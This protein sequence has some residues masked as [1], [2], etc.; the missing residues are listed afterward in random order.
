MEDRGGELLS[1]SCCYYYVADEGFEGKSDGLIGRG[2]STFPI[3][4]FGYA[5]LREGL[6]LC[7]H[8]STV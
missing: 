4:R 2:F 5:P 6:H 7:E 8:V 3:K 1:K